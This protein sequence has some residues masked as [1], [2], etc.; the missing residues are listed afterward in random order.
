VD[1]ARADARVGCIVPT[2][3]RDALLKRA[4]ESITHQTISPTAVFVVD[5]LGSPATRAVLETVR[6]PPGLELHY[7]DASGLSHPGASASRN[8]GAAAARGYAVDQLAFLDDDDYWRPDYLEILLEEARRTGAPLVTSWS[9]LDRVGRI[10]P[11]VWRPAAG[12]TAEAVAADNPGVTGSNFVIRRADFEAI[13]GFDEHQWA[14]N[15]L[16]LLVRYLDSGRPYA[17]V[18]RDLVYQSS[19]PGGHVSS[20]SDRR[21]EAIRRYADKHAALLSPRQRR[22]LRREEHLA[23]LHAGQRTV[24]RAVHLAAALALSTPTDLARAVLARTVGPPG[25]N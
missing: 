5:D 12:L 23:R 22:K 11:H 9:A 3:G 10:Y 4:L 7:L 6:R 16:D 25:Y 21:A 15:D 17:V 14:Y 24:R 13:G 19:S 8:M 18:P 1:D 20:R 2:H